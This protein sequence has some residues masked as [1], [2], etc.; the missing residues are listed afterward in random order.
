[1]EVVA[2]LWWSRLYRRNDNSWTFYCQKYRHFYKDNETQ[3]H[4]GP[5]AVPVSIVPLTSIC[6]TTEGNNRDFVVLSPVNSLSDFEAN[7]EWSNISEGFDYALKDET[8]LLDRFFP[9]DDMC[10][11]LVEGIRNGT[12]SVVSDGSF[13]PN[14]AIGQAGTSAVILAPSTTCQ[15]KHWAKGENWVT[16][17][18]EAQSAYRSELA[19]VIAG[20][21]I[22][23]ILV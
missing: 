9:P 10:N 15:P 7:S 12:A 13:E 20:L 19:G 21:T 17:P 14:S 18:E 5:D 6:V 11:S 23:D 16:G 2:R 1:M 3:N 8:I 22:I 4:P